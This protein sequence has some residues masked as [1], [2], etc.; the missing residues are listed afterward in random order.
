MSKEYN[1]K[2]HK[3][4]T[5]FYNLTK[6]PVLVNTSFNVRGEPMVCTPKDAYKCFMGTGL[7]VLVCEN[8]ILLKE[9]QNKNKINDYKSEFEL[10]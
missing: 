9:K 8:Y 5:E 1:E 2:F 6:C 3:L 10:D 4:L 7:D